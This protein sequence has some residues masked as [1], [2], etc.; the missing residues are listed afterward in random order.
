MTKQ[1]Q[2]HNEFLEKLQEIIQKNLEKPDFSIVQICI[3][4]NIS[5]AQ[6]HRKVKAA[7]G[8]ST[9][10][11]IR[12]VRMEQ[13]KKLLETTDFNV[14]EIA[15]QIGVSS[16]QNFSKYFIE[17]YGLSPSAYRKQRGTP[18]A[19]TTAEA[20]PVIVVPD[21]SDATPE[22]FK[23]KRQS[24]VRW[25]LLVLVCLL[26]GTFIV[27]VQEKKRAVSSSIPTTSAEAFQEVM[28]GKQ[29]LEKRTQE[30][31]RESMEAFDRAIQLD[32]TY[33]DAYL[34]KASGLNLL[35]NLQYSSA[36]RQDLRQAEQL[37][38]L[39]IKHNTSNAQAYA[40]L[41][42]IY[43]DQYRWQEALTVY[44]I[45]L[46][47]QPQDA[48]TNYWYSLTL[49]SIGDLEQALQYHRLAYELDPAYPV[50][51]GGYIYTAIFANRFDLADTLLQL[52][53]PNFQ[54]SF[55]YPNVMG[56]L[57]LAKEQYEPALAHFDTCLTM[58]PRYRSVQVSRIFCLGKIG[59]RQAV[60]DFLASLDTTRAE[61][62]L[63]AAA[64]HAGLGQIEQGMTYLQAAADKGKI[65]EYLLFDFC[66]APLQTHP[67]FHNILQA[68]GLQ[69]MQ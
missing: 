15:Y 22:P 67:A 21:V 7:T 5:R 40:V 55:L 43:R 31:L 47:L 37:A 49:R 59:N 69:P 54:Q 4:M 8:F 6:L 27:S 39:A 57:Y 19:E 50:I 1:K 34:G 28:L 58:N 14:S 52:A 18:L 3:E 9:S 23:S 46:K 25:G 12:H 51:A 42:N 60:K 62:C 66:Y 63:A 65:P 48:L 30:S 10:L 36:E 24:A 45:A 41:G 17:A 29:L 44:Q 68:Y 20:A 56:L 38:L 13:A 26:I 11:L 16:P 61:D 64:A 32:S 53:T 33:S 2:L 35:V